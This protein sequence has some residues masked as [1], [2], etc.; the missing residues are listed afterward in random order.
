MH[1]GLV[2]YNW[3]KEWDLPTLINNCAATGFE[4]VELRST[5]AHGVEI[6]LSP[7]DREA[8]VDQFNNSP[9]MLVGLGS[10]CE[11]HSPDPAI[12]KKNIEETKD[13]IDLC[14][15]IG[16][17]GVKVRP[18]GLPEEVPVDK[19]IEQIGKALNEVATYGYRLGI[20]IR[21]EVH[22]KGTRDWPNFKYIMDAADHPGVVVC[23]NCNASDLE[24]Q[25]LKHNFNLVKDRIGTVHIHDLRN[26]DIYPWKETFALLKQSGF[27]GWTLLEEGK[28]PE[29]II[30]AM[31]ENRMIWE[32]LT[33]A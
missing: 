6:N 26:N 28:P 14:H 5:H 29:D 31:K 1:L 4:G 33:G 20:E 7:S 12:L 19:T 10:A 18:N 24:G 16:G 23:W 32:N 30:G 22:G 17:T 9:V 3:G 25:G 15:D 2:T 13:F 27:E 21:V 11:Y 8:V